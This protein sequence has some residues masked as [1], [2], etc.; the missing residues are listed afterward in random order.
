MCG[1]FYVNT[2]DPV[3]ESFFQPDQWILP[4]A[5]EPDA[6]ALAPGTHIESLVST[7]EIFPD[8]SVPVLT[9]VN[10]QV[11]PR[12]MGWGFPKWDGH[13]VQFNA[14]SETAHELK[15]FKESLARWRVAVPTSGFYEWRAEQGVAKKTRY[16]FTDP[17]NPVLYLA[18]I[19]GIFQRAKS[20]VKDRFTIL[21][22]SS[23]G[24]DVE[25]YHNRIPVILRK[26]DLISWL[27]GPDYAAYFTRKPFNLAVNPA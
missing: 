22:R 7:G 25:A 18:A 27:Q 19:A 21:T 3:I 15:S 11:R 10:G 13:G 5:N 12:L 17:E 26:E 14:R 1:R 16:L 8:N 4:G 9:L 24:T 20:P 2:S 6:F 23:V